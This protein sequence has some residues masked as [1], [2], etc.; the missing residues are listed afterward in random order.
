MEHII[1]DPDTDETALERELIITTALV[2]KELVY[3]HWIEPF[4]GHP[5][6]CADF[7][8][9]S[10]A[11]VK[12]AEELVYVARRALVATQVGDRSNPH[13]ASIVIV[14]PIEDRSS[15]KSLTPEQLELV[16]RLGERHAFA[17]VDLPR[18]EREQ[19]ELVERQR[20][21]DEAAHE[22][23]MKA[24]AIESARLDVDAL[25]ERRDDRQRAQDD[26]L[27]QL[28][29]NGILLSVDNVHV[30]AM[31]LSM[32]QNDL[33]RALE[34]LVELGGAAEIGGFTSPTIEWLDEQEARATARDAA[35]RAR[36]DSEPLDAPDQVAEIA[37]DVDEPSTIDTSES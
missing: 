1:R 27:S 30:A 23:R 17:A 37:P 15:L 28:D 21:E 4:V 8:T 34:E 2:H 5:S 24:I 22:A 35:A 11:G 19:A 25:R 33:E 16:D 26:V 7:N 32:A 6:I 36:L 13:R 18:I 20:L 29:E 10:I 14:R 12:E 31:E 3:R 9:L